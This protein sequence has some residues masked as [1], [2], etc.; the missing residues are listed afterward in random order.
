M[1]RPRS[2][3]QG[4]KKIYLVNKPQDQFKVII[5]P[6][7]LPNIQ[8]KQQ[9]KYDLRDDEFNEELNL[10]KAQ[11]D[12]LGIANEYRAIF[13][14]F[15]KN[16]NDSDR[17]DIFAQEKKNLKK[18][19]DCIINLKKEIN[20]RENYI[21]I[22]KQLDKNIKDFINL[23]NDKTSIDKI[24]KDVINIIK[25]LRKSAINIVTRMIEVNK[26]S[27]IYKIWGKFERNKMKSEYN[28]DPRYLF[29]MKEDLFF[30]KN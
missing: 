12:D 19:R 27:N 15:L 17:K 26:L 8:Y 5:P 14:N 28:Y 16:I 7:S 1:N 9:S 11:W 20:S 18:F 4:P 25:N 10:I 30:L 2:A 22:L 6:E 13:I 21:S 24:L 29:K 3:N 23:G